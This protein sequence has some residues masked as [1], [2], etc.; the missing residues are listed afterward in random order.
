[1]RNS[2][3]TKYIIILAL[4]IA[5]TGLSLG[6]AAFSNTLTIKSS[7]TVTNP[8]DS[9][10]VLSTSKTAASTGNVTPT[11]TGGASGSTASIASATPTTISNVKA[12]FT[13]P[14]QTV[15]YTLAAYNTGDFLYYLNQVNLGSKTCTAKSG[16]TQSYVD[17]ACNSISISVKVGSTTYSSTNTSIS[18]HSLAKATGEDVV[19]TISYASGGAVADGDFDVAFGDANGDIK[20]VYGTAD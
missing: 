18:S 4:L 5:V 2:N 3:G 8:S 15:V 13:G 1:M 9:G 10:V 6:F 19:V 20:L 17:T 14:G 16:T 12:T 7:A 11:T